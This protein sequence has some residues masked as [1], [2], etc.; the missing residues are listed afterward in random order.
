MFYF[1]RYESCASARL[2]MT[3][4][5]KPNAVMMV[6]DLAYADD[7]NLDDRVG[8]Q[9]RWDIWGRVT[10]ALFSTIPFFSCIGAP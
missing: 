9:P 1:A 4:A 10:Q 2:H 7:Y 6:G 3:Q 5:D 8:Y